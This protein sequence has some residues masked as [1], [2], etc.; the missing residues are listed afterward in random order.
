MTIRGLFL[1]LF[2]LANLLLSACSGSGHT[3]NSLPFVSASD[4][5]AASSSTYVPAGS[6]DW[7]L[8]VYP[9]PGDPKVNITRFIAWTAANNA[10]AYELQI[11]TTVG[12]N[13]VFDSGIVTATSV[14]MPPLP[15]S[16]VLYARVRAIL[17]GWGDA[18]P[19][20]HWS[21]GSYTS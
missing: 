18:S 20:G 9:Q 8:F 21:R 6:S 10:R 15:A 19:A 13:D 16:V 4:S 1:G 3:A 5:G 7:P 17:N 2:L 14:A 12:G 11:G